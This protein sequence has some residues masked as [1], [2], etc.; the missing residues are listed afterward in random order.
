MASFRPSPLSYG[1]VNPEV[2]A[3]SAQLLAA[4]T[5]T[6]VVV[7]GEVQKARARKRRRKR[8][9]RKKR[10]K[11]APVI[12]P[13]QREDQ[14]VAPPTPPWLVPVVVLGAL[15]LV[16]MVYLSGQDTKKASTPKT[17]KRPT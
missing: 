4:A 15:G 3:A 9:K 7:A 13:K 17:K 6:G 12:A 5:G 11:E 2:I 1:A 8:K 16:G 14:P 10:K